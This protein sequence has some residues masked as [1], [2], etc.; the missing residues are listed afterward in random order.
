MSL[1]AGFAHSKLIVTAVFELVALD[2][3]KA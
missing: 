1:H 3:K 2:K